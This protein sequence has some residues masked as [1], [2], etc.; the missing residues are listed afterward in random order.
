MVYNKSSN[1]KECPPDQR[2]SFSAETARVALRFVGDPPQADF[3]SEKRDGSKR[4]RPVGVLAGARANCSRFF[5][6]EES[7]ARLSLCGSPLG[8]EPLVETTGQEGPP[9]RAPNAS[10]GSAYGARYPPS[11]KRYAKGKGEE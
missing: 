6:S 2:D 3:R 9:F 10:D 5:V 1:R 7:F 4:R 8:E 11:P